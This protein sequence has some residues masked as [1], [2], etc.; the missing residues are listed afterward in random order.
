MGAVEGQ[1]AAVPVVWHGVDSSPIAVTASTD[2]TA[3]YA[4]HQ[5]PGHWHVG[6][7][8]RLEVAGTLAGTEGTKTISVRLNGQQLYAFAIS[9]TLVPSWRL[10]LQI[11]M[12]SADEA[13]LV[14][15]I[16]YYTSRMV[17][18]VKPIAIDLGADNTLT[19]SG[20]LSDPS[21]TLTREFAKAE[22]VSHP[23]R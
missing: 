14:A 2:D 16:G 18:Q 9:R 7:E 1:A 20:R 11:V 22:T 12:R 4:C 3:L 19:V 15:Q 10:Q 13:V 5:P 8:F 23:L 21:D 17:H 6:D